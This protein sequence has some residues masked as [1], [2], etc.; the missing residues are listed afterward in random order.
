MTDQDA[1]L[2]CEVDVAVPPGRAALFLDRD[3][4][5]VTDTHYLCR[6]E[7]MRM[8]AG[9]AAAIARCNRLNI[10]VVVVT[11]QAGIGRGY[12]GWDDFHAVQG[13][14]AT[15]LAADGAHLDGVVAC[16]YHADGRA[17][18]RV[19]NHPWRK[20]N[21]GM[22]VE[23]ARRM[24]LDLSRSWIVGDRAHD[25]AAGATAQLAGGTLLA[26]DAQERQAAAKLASARFMVDT[27]SD[28]A[29]AVSALLERRQFEDRGHS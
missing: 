9:A 5:I 8:I 17:P 1:G 7:D 24:R 13:A 16:A 29:A 27:A 10:P 12:Y 11:N 22:I 26:A 21:P 14:L 15:A 4:V 23:A 20:P 25:L 19:D 3:G 2:W 6:V 18:L 28:L